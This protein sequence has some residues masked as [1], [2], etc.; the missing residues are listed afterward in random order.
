MCDRFEKIFLVKSMISRAEDIVRE[1]ETTYQHDLGEKDVSAKARNLTHEILEKCSNALDQAMTILFDYEIRSRL[2]EAPKRGGYFPIAK[3]I[4]AYRSSLG[5]WN[6]KDLAI[7]A[8]DLDAKLLSL[9]PFTKPQNQ[10]FLRMRELANRKHTGLTP[11]KRLEQRRVNVTSPSGGSVSWGPGVTF[12]S[13]VS[14]MGVPIDPS[15]QMP[16]HSNG[17]SIEVERWISFHFDDGGEDALLFCK[18]SISA[19]RRAIDALLNN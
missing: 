16:A 12:G 5:Q 7:F 2:P 13:G 9:Q 18:D 11:Q 8:P 15:T 19:T 14:I 6:A 1:L 10:I 3:D 17:I 4:D